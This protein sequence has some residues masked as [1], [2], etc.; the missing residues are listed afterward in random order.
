MILWSDLTRHVELWSLENQTESRISYS[1]LHRSMKCE[2]NFSG[3]DLRMA[4][5]PILQFQVLR[6]I[7]FYQ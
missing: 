5:H 7:D 2:I 3:K 6:F 4:S 1:E